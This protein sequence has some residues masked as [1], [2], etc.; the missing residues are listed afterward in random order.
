[1]IK[2]LNKRGNEVLCNE[3]KLTITPPSPPD[4]FT[5]ARLDLDVP[6]RS[7]LQLKDVVKVIMD[8]EYHFMVF[9]IMVCPH[10]KLISLRPTH[11]QQ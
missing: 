7:K 5:E 8:R 9:S 6:L 4:N 1:M 2:I 11:A 10:H 3:I